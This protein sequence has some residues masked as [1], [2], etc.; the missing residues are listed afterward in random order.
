[1]PEREPVETTNLDS[2]GHAAL[3]WSRARDTFATDSRGPGVTH[4]LVTVRPDG[5]PHAAGVG[6]LWFDGD[7]YFTAG[8]RRRKA[9]NLEANPACTLSARL[10]GIDV[11]IEGVASRVVDPATLER[12]AAVYR[13]AG[14]PAEV[15]GDAFSAPY[16]APSAGPPPWH[17]YC[18]TIHTAFG[19]TGAEPYGATRWRFDSRG[20]ATLG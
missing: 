5:R 13:D 11:V 6:A 14:W 20:S 8:P 2:Y 19:V 15:Q 7:V 9:R 17:L 18:L 10:T 1:M 3:A 4:F 12:L 16:S